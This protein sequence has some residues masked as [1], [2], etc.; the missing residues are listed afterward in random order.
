ML[1]T[2]GLLGLFA[3]LSAA[4]PVRVQDVYDIKLK[5]SGKGE[6]FTQRRHET[7]SS[8]FK[9]E[10]S[11]GSQL[12]EKKVT[13]TIEDE[14]KET[15]LEKERGKRAS[16]LR[17]EYRKA[18]SK[19][20]GKEVRLPYDGKTLL[21]E[22]KN[23]KYHFTIEG[24]EEL[25]GEDAASFDNS[26]N[27]SGL[28]DSERD[29]FEKAFLPKK[30][31][32]LNETWNFDPTEVV[33]AFEKGMTLSLPVVKN[34]IKAEC[35]LLRVYKKDGRQFGAFDI[36]L[37]LPLKGKFAMGKEM[38]ATVQEGSKMHFL[39]KFDG[40]IDGSS[41]D[42]VMEGTMEIDLEA[43]YKTSD[44]EIKLTLRAS[45]KEKQDETDLSKK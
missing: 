20:D 45:H 25:K 12:L 31:V 15:V 39:A 7:E 17:R 36:D 21:I 14:F 10:D 27:N 6:S 8:T 4:A 22:K 44:Q 13:K 24:G 32:K 37:D 38:D 43:T 26:F 29:A 33:K 30:P 9:L 18:V 40:C 28:T 19:S 1:R 35:K 41:S 3:S 42:G 34:K 23:D 5:K 2:I 11:A 16:K